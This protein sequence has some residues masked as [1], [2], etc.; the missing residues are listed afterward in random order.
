ML[1]L[2]TS[3]DF[4]RTDLQCFLINPDMYLAPQAALGPSVLARVPLTFPF[5]LDASAVH[6]PAGDHAVICRE[7]II[8]YSLSAS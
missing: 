5:S 4:D 6:C 3:G 2:V 7:G 8:A 1:L